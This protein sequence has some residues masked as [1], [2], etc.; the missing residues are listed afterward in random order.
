MRRRRTTTAPDLSNPAAVYLHGWASN[1]FGHRLTLADLHAAIADYGKGNSAFARDVAGVDPRQCR[2]WLAG[3]RMRY[4][5]ATT[6][7]QWREKRADAVSSK[8]PRAPR[9]SD[10]T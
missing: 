8:R 1:T 9:S 4:T 5:A 6:I 3:A 7:L 10:K 2:R